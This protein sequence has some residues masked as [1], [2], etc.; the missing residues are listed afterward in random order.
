M[1]HMPILPNGSLQACGMV[2]AAIAVFLQS[3]EAYAEDTAQAAVESAS[4]AGALGG[5]ITVAVPPS[6]LAGKKRQNMKL[7]IGHRQIPDCH[8]TTVD[9]RNGALTFVLKRT[10]ESREA[11]AAIL[12]NPIECSKRVHISVGYGD[13]PPIDSNH[14]LELTIIPLDLTL[15][16]CL[17]GLLITTVVFWNFA[18][19]SNILRDSG[20]EPAGGARKPYSLSRT[21][22][23]FWFFIV[24]AAYLLLWVV[25]RDRDIM[26]IEVLAL[27]GISTSTALGAVAI[28]AGR[29]TKVSSH[30]EAANNRRT[31]LEQIVKALEAKVTS[32]KATGEETTELRNSTAEIASVD[33]T[34]ATLT[35]SLAPA[36]SKGFW[37]DLVQ[38]ADGVSLHR[39]QIIVWTGVLGVVFVWTVFATLAMPVFSTTL[40]ALQGM[41]GATYIG[42][43]F[44]ESAAT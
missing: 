41:S 7:Y 42:F 15:G 10:A 32:G 4:P 8:P 13:D 25:T 3:Q 22:M 14:E 33:G 29:R 43:K 21:Q 16:V 36:A 20:P 39:F 9:H 23:A 6:W 34:I 1:Y 28:D 31:V 37:R 24:L 18:V 12:A 40:L 11:W 19:S 17:V 30:R 2:I 38:D 26:P 5:T 27:I 44:P 35:K